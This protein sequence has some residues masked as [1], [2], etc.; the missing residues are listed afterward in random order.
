MSPKIHTIFDEKWS[1]WKILNSVSNKWDVLH[2]MNEHTM[3]SWKWQC[4]TKR[5]SRNQY[6]QTQI[7]YVANNL[8]VTRWPRSLQSQ[9]R[10]TTNENQSFNCGTVQPVHNTHELIIKA[11]YNLYSFKIES[12]HLWEVMGWQK[13]RLKHWCLIEISTKTQLIMSHT[14]YI[15]IVCVKLVSKNTIFCKF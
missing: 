9:L 4:V 10:V 15:V 8:V 7:A 2:W 14:N 12:V 13:C 5:V 1:L 6:K 3:T 11:I